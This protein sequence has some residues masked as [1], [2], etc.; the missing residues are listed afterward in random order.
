MHPQL[1]RAL[2]VVLRDLRATKA[3]VP[4]LTDEQWSGDPGTGTAMLWSEDGSAAGVFVL[5]D[6]PAAD[7]LTRVADTVHDWVL[8]EL[9]GTS[10]TNWPPC[11][12]HPGTH[13]LEVATGTNG[14]PS[15]TCPRDGTP[16][17]RI[18]ELG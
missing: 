3:P 7:Q 5:V 18:G 9:R 4:R 13:P 11:P 14:E 8:D 1:Q 12:R 10:A 15:W 2:D 17:C 6:E 16:V